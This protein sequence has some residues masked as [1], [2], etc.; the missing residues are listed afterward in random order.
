ML[1][2]NI[3]GSIGYGRTYQ[4]LIF[5]DWGGGDLADLR[6]AVEWLRA[7][8]WVDPDRIGVYGGSYGGFAALSCLTRLPEYWAAGVAVASAANLVSWTR[9]VPPTWHRL[10]ARWVG[11]PETEEDFLL[12]HSP[13]TYVDQLTAPL[14]MLQG[15]KDPRA[16]VAESDQLVARLR[17]RDR[18]VEYVVFEDEGHGFTRRAN[19]LRAMELTA[20]WFTRH[21]L[22]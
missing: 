2:P 5:R 14:L 19:L 20:G 17:E 4:Q 11:D 22:S 9:S 21:L 7:Q 18:P 3:R 16:V 12:A 15:A 10:M 6:C 8:D 13:I 1:A